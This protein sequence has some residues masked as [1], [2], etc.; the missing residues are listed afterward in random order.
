MRRALALAAGIA[1]GACAPLK[2]PKG[3]SPAAAANRVTVW[4]VPP[5]PSGDQM[6]VL[7]E[8][9]YSWRG[10]ALSTGVTFYAPEGPCS[11]RLI[12]AGQVVAETAL[13]IPAGGRDFDW[14]LGR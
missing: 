7:H 12:R 2:A 1:L 13:K 8:S 9:G 4:F 6:L 3:A 11:L 10:S 14:S 5:Q